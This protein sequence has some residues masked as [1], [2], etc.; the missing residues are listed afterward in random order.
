MHELSIARSLVGLVLENVPTDTSVRRVRVR[1]GPLQ[2]VDADAMRLA[3]RA[4]TEGTR[5]EGAKLSLTYVPWVLCCRECGRGWSSE[6][7]SDPC[8]CGSCRVDPVGGD[9]LILE[10]IDVDETEP[11][12]ART[13][14]ARP[15]I[16][17]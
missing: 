9:E 7:W 11:G 13:Q 6:S 10:S 15:A 14:D 8:T 4:A 5:L 1:I 2:A 12:T 3:W 17:N 16:Q